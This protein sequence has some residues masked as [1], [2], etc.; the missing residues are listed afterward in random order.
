MVPLRG[1]G[2]GSRLVQLC[3]YKVFVESVGKF[4]MGVSEN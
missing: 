3:V 2:L 4:Y 1:S